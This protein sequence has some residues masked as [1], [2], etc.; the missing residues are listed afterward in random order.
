MSEELKSDKM[1]KRLKLP[2]PRKEGELIEEY[3]LIYKENDG[4]D[5]DDLGYRALLQTGE[6]APVGELLFCGSQVL[7]EIM[8][9][10]EKI[11]M[12]E[13]L[14]QELMKAIENFA[15]M[16]AKFEKIEDIK[17]GMEDE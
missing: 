11:P 3:I 2:H 1:S 10:Q 8:S 4:N 6:S 12:V 13:A 14:G 15:E 7:A 5:Y 16:L 9:V 17:K